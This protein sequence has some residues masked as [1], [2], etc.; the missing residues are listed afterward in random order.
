MT[1][2]DPLSLLT[3]AWAASAL[4]MAALWLL[5]RRLHNLALA[6]VGWCYGLALVVLWY[7]MTVS[8]EPA[9][10]LLVC[11]MIVLYAARLG[12]HV[13]TDRLWGTSEDG[14]Y[15]ALREQWGEQ[16]PFRRFWYFQLQ[17][18]AIVWFSLP[19]LVVM[20]NP[21]PPFHLLELL[22]VLLWMVAVAGEAVADWQLASFRRQPWNRDRV[23]RE[24]LWYYSR[25]PNYFFEWLHWWSYVVMGLA[26]PLGNWGLT[27]IGP[28][29]MGWALLKVTGVPWTETQTMKSRGEEYVT[30]RRTTNA[31]IPWFPRRP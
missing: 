7:A 11:G 25:H 27:L 17:A 14:R 30:Y 18:A 16:G 1:A 13:L 3:T 6:D 28:L 10:R 22:G 29:T 15:G 19:P 2:T 21:H 31:F 26:S 4:L 24:G 5:E 23:C 20:Q 9:R 12:T 8:G